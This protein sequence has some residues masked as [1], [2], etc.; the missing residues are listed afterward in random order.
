MARH[1]FIRATCSGC[2]RDPR[3]LAS[4]AGTTGKLTSRAGRVIH[5]R[6]LAYAYTEWRKAPGP[7]TTARLRAALARARDNH[8]EGLGMPRYVLEAD[9]ASVS[10]YCVRC[11]RAIEDRSDTH[12]F[13]WAEVAGEPHAGRYGPSGGHS[14]R[15]FLAMHGSCSRDARRAEARHQLELGHPR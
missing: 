13:A 9:P 4:Q 10:E 3:A 7:R 1:A 12:W 15:A 2:G 8:S 14:H 5:A 11:G 6:G